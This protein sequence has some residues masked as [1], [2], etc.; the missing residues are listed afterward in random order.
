MQDICKISW[1][2]LQMYN[3][4][5]YSQHSCTPFTNTQTR[6]TFP[7]NLSKVEVALSKLQINNRTL[8]CNIA[9]LYRKQHLVWLYII[10]HNF[11]LDCFKTGKYTQ[12]GPNTGGSNMKYPVSRNDSGNG[13]VIRDYLL[14]AYCGLHCLKDLTTSID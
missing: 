3:R 13:I 14:H 9:K 6:C 7:L 10:K 11:V 2:Y 12:H 4:Y 5:I 8:C 1:M